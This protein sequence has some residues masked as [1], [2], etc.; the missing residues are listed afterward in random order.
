MVQAV[1][2]TERSDIDATQ[3][4]SKSKRRRNGWL[5]GVLVR[6]TNHA[7]ILFSN[8]VNVSH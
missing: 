3:K 2:D 7:L 8:L 6:L 1:R 4:R 5:F